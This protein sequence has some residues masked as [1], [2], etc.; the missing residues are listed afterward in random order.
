MRCSGGILEGRERV[1]LVEVWMTTGQ[2]SL[3]PDRLL[4]TAI[5]LGHAPDCVWDAVDELAE[6]DL[7][8]L[9]RLVRQAPAESWL[10]RDVWQRAIQPENVRRLLD[11]DDSDPESVR[12]LLD[13]FG[14]EDADVLLDLL[15]AS[16]SIA[17]RKRLFARLVELAPQIGQKLVRLSRDKRW[18]ARRNV[19]ALMGELEEWPRKWSPGAFADDPHPAVRRE[20]FKL[21][22]RKPQLRDQALC[23][24]LTDDD[25]RARSLGLAAATESCPPEAIYALSDI[26]VNEGIATEQRVMGVRALGRSG[27]SEALRPLI[28]V[29]R[30]GAGL[31][32]NRLGPKTPVMLAALQA[33][34]TFPGDIGAGKKLIMKASRSNDPDIRAALGKDA[35]A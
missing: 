9:V 30:S 15:C 14:P 5:E 27:D 21:M 29:V 26:V 3:G 4:M 13:G 12:A 7:S 19:L 18:F 6:T 25:G 28:E 2:Q 16:E 8:L 33:L 35:S 23:G 11:D 10:A 22:L 20:A 31:A 34:A 1:G 17:T 32:P 24:L